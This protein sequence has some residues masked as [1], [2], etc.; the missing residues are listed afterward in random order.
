MPQL[1]AT[2]R[3]IAAGGADEFYRGGLARRIVDGARE[4]GSLY[5]YEDFERY[6][7]EWQEP[8]SISYRGYQVYTRRRPTA[9]PSRYCRPSSCWRDG[10]AVGARVPAPRHGA[11]DD[12]GR[13]A[14][15]HRPHRVRR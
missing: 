6:Q 9:A 5:S 8:I 14:L 10:R 4:L 15:R 2:L 13:K 7:A 1:A 11:P 12:G 3:Q